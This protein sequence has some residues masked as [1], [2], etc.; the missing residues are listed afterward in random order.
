M[1]YSYSPRDK[2]NRATITINGRKVGRMHFRDGDAWLNPYKRSKLKSKSE[3]E[4][5]GLKVKIDPDNTSFPIKV[6]IKTCNEDGIA[7]ALYNAFND[8]N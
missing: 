8:L 1:H 4:A 7:K 5:L 6:Y 2:A 3:L